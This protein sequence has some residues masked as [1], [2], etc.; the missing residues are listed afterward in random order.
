MCSS[1]QNNEF[2]PDSFC[3]RPSIQAGPTAG[4][5]TT[6]PAM[7]F[8]FR[9]VRHCVRLSAPVVPVLACTG[10]YTASL[11]QSSA[12]P[13]NDNFTNAT[14]VSGLS[15]TANGNNFNATTEPGEP[16][17]VAVGFNEESVW[18]RWTAPASGS[19]T[20]STLGSVDADGVDPMDTILGIY[21]G[22][23]VDSLS[24]IIENDDGPV[25]LTSLVTFPAIAGQTYYILVSGFGP[26]EGTIRLT[27][28]V[29]T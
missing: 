8:L 24:S 16:V 22:N 11:S 4:F 12:Q 25:D 15:G 2:V 29:S 1:R 14:V 5:T 23:S 21:T 20:F 19:A 13:A 17:F 26:T 28:S 18:Y 27:W 6:T 9:L 3:P 7:N 10:F